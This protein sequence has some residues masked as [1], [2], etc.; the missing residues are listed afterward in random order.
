MRTLGH[1]RW[2]GTGLILAVLALPSAWA[3][4]NQLR[5]L[6]Y[7]IHHGEGTD[8]RLVTI[9]FDLKEIKSGNLED[10]KLLAGDRIEVGR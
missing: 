6:A 10:P 3:A 5:V 2:F 9:R 7:N 8:G 4:P 1:Q